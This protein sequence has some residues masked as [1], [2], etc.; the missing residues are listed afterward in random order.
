MDKSIELFENITTCDVTFPDEPIMS[1]IFESDCDL[2]P[3]NK[4]SVLNLIN[5][6]NILKIKL[7]R[8]LRNLLKQ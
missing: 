5:S 8:L 3:L 6:K 1:P 4:M 7:S 2:D